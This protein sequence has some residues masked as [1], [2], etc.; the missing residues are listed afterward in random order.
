MDV[1]FLYLDE[2]VDLDSAWLTGL[3]VPASQYPDVRDGVIRIA[4]KALLAAGASAVAPIELHG[5]DMLKGVAGATDEHRLQVFSKVVELVNRYRLEVVSVGHVEKKRVRESFQNL[6]MDPGDKLHRLNFQEL[7]DILH[8]PPDVLVVP[9]FDG[10]P[11]RPPTGGMEPVDRFAYEAFLLGGSIT[12]WNRVMLEERPVGGLSHKENLRNLMEPVFSDSARSPILQLADIIGYL[13]GVAERVKQVQG[14]AWK[15]QLANV[16]GRI[17]KQ[18]LHR[19]SVTLSFQ[20][21]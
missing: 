10:I 18:L 2:S 6:H 1:V 21:P 3:L 14:S 15:V 11:G 13:L 4:R 12:H 19:R 7:V 16:A 17:D 5:V 9:V 20:G 8:L